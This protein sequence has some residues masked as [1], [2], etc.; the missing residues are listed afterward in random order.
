[1]GNH[2]VF[3]PIHVYSRGTWDAGAV[4]ALDKRLLKV[5]FRPAVERPKEAALE[6]I[7]QSYRTDWLISLIALT[8]YSVVLFSIEP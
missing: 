1:M 2:H 6:R 8:G 4:G 7:Q 3:M 5:A